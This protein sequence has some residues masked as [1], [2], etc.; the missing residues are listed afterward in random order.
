MKEKLVNLKLKLKQKAKN[1]KNI[2]IYILPKFNNLMMQMFKLAQ[3]SRKIRH[4][5][6]YI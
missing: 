4:K 6:I 5:K 3:E 1:Y 2:K